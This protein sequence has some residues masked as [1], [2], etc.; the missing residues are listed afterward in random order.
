M[1]YKLLYP[2]EFLSAC[3]LKGDTDVTIESIGM[4]TLT[5]VGGRKE[6]RV[7][8]KF[9][10]AKKRMVLNKTNATTIAKK[11]GSET[12]AWKGK[13]I[14]VFPTTTKFGNETVECVRI[15]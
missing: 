4:E 7:V 12:D 1:H 13:T 6:D 14:T 8:L 11:F 2:T 15:K 10:K 9:N 5:C 3:D